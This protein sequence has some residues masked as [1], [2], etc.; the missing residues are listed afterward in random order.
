MLNN[1]TALW[2]T[3]NST[4]PFLITN[5]TTAEETA[6]SLRK[7]AYLDLGLFRSLRSL[8]TPRD[9]ICTTLNLT[10]D[11]YDYICSLV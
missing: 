1:N 10:G 4:T 8:G 11:E 9:R 3:T 6:M 2:Q 7:L 5:G